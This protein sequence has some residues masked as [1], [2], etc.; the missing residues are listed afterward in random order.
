VADYAAPRQA[1]PGEKRPLVRTRP[2]RGDDLGGIGRSGLSSVDSAWR[3]SLDRRAGEASRCFPHLAQ[4]CL[5]D[6]GASLVAGV[7]NRVIGPWSKLSALDTISPMHRPLPWNVGLGSVLRAGPAFTVYGP[8]TICI[9]R[10]LQCQ[11]YPIVHWAM[12]AFDACC[13]IRSLRS[14]F[15]QCN[16]V[17]PVNFE[18]VPITIE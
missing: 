9:C 7:A 3:K 4:H 11:A 5:R 2:I 6:T 12:S 14:T 16:F 1:D 15:T 10:S 17:A 8:L 18:H 13:N